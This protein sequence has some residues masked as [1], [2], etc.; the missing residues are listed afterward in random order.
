[1]D[2]VTD[3]ALLGLGESIEWTVDDGT[4]SITLPDRLPVSAAHAL[5]ITGAL[6]PT[7]ALAIDQ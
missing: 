7:H 1:M 5:R 6:H 2:D 4:L 3:V